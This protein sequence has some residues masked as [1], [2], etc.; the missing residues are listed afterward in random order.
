M[1]TDASGNIAADGGATL[2]AIGNNTTNIGNNASAISLNTTAINDNA[3]AISGLQGSIG[4]NTGQIAQNRDGIA[5]AMALAGSS[6]LQA[7]EDFAMTFNVGHFDGSDAFAATLTGRINNQTSLNGGVT[8][9]GSG[10]VGARAGLRF[11]W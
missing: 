1:T 6:W 7:N 9:S 5:M 8:V 10:E 2:T 11:G 4:A 3:T